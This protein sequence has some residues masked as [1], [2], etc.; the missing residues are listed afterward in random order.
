[1]RVKIATSVSVYS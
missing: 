1:M